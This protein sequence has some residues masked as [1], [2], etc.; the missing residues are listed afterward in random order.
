MQLDSIDNGISR[1]IKLVSEASVCLITRFR[2]QFYEIHVLA[3]NKKESS[4]EIS[5][6]LTDSRAIQSQYWTLFAVNTVDVLK[7]F[8]FEWNVLMASSS[9]LCFVQQQYLF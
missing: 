1:R 2:H 4:A 7:Y 6:F 5:S 3:V 8:S 9:L